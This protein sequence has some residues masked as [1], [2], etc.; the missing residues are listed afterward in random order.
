M[1]VFLVIPSQ[2]CL[3]CMVNS[4]RLDVS[5]CDSGLVVHAHRS[6]YKS[7]AYWVFMQPVKCSQLFHIHWDSCVQ[8]NK[9]KNL[10]ALLLNALR[11][12]YKVCKSAG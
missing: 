6:C 3:K 10:H 9:K 7:T 8:S 5:N 4:L 1:P 12:Y 11:E 2:Y